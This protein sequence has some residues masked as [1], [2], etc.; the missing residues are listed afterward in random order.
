VDIQPI[1][2]QISK[3]RFFISLVVEQ[4]VNTETDNLGIR[5]LPN[6]ETKF[7]AANTLIGIERPRQQVLRNPD[8]NAKEGELRKVR[9]DH[10][11]AKTPEKK[12]KCREQDAKL[13]SEIAQLLKAEG[14]GVATANE[15]ALWDPYDQNA[16]AGFSRQRTI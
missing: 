14:W 5:P 10:F 13:R 9:E 7:V 8:I 16:S 6:L 15:L 11:L 4:K 3:L 12:R 2:V 1:A